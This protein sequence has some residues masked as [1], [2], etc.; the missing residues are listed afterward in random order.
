VAGFTTEALVREKFQLTDA[1]Q[2]L[3]SLVNRNIDDAHLILLRFLDPVFDL[4][5]PAAAV[6]LGETL[7]AGAYLLRSLAGGAAFRRRKVTVGGQ[8]VE[9]SGNSEAMLAQADTAEAEAWRALEPYLV[10]IPTD[11]LA[12][13]TDSQSIVGDD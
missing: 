8:K 4:P 2:V 11:R 9:P 12:A 10:V 7:L 1:A 13:A 3:P 5:S 6:V